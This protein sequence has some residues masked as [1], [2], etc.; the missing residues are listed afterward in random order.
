M[1]LPPAKPNQR[2]AQ[3]HFHSLGRAHPSG[4]SQDDKKRGFFDGDD[5]ELAPSPLFKEKRSTWKKGSAPK[6]R[7]ARK[8]RTI[9]EGQDVLYGNEIM[10]PSIKNLEASKIW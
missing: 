5:E 6:K 1:L 8:K 7:S 9:A 3:S 4:T 2:L 10:A